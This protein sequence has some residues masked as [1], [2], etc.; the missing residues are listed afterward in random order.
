MLDNNHLTGQIPPEFS[1]LERIK[2]FSVAN[3]RLSGAVPVFSN[4]S[5]PAESYA[6]NSGLCGGPMNACSKDDD[7]FF[8]GFAVGFPIST[9]LSMLFMFLCWPRLRIR[10]S[11]YYP[12]W[13]KKRERRTHHLIPRNPQVLFAE[14]V[15]SMET[16]V[17]A[18]EKFICRFSLLELEMATNDFDNKNVIG[19][20][21]MGLMYKGECPKGLLVAIKRL[22]RFESFEKEFLSEIEILGRL[23]HTN[24]VQML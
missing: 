10:T 24:L 15:S 1:K 9:I 7:L 6:N 13:I 22:H 20:G 4:T 2:E 3:N 11:R 8:P 12:F 16:K 17:V 14:N 18:M 19:Y 5:F 21:N 23:S